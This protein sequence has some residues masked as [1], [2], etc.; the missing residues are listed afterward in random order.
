MIDL[1]SLTQEELTQ[2]LKEM[3][4]PAF[5]GKQ[6]FTWLYRGVTSFDEM[7]NLPKALREKLKEQCILT[8]PP[9]C[10]NLPT[11]ASAPANTSPR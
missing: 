1:K 11:K 3:G 4:E 5:R 9:S 8:V 10:N 6:V 2:A 7:S